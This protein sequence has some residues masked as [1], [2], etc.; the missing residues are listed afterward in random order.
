MYKVRNMDINSLSPYIRV[1]ANSR[2]PAPFVI[3]PRCILDYELIM[4]EEGA[5][6][7]TY[8]DKT[9]EVG[10]GS[11]LFFRPGIVHSIEL[12][13][14]HP[15][16]TQPHIHFDMFFDVYSRD[17]YVCFKGPSQL[18]KSD[19][20]MMRSDL[21]A[22][23]APPSPVLHIADLPRF[24]TYFMDIISA[25]T[26]KPPHHV[27]LLK[28]KMLELLTMIIFDNFPQFLNQNNE[29]SGL[30]IQHIKNYIDDNLLSVIT[31]D[32]LGELFNFNKY[33]ILRKFREEYGV[34]P[35]KYHSDLRLEYA[36]T[37]LLTYSVTDVAHILNY[38]SI[39]TF[40]RAFITKF[41]ISPTK[42]KTS[43]NEINHQDGS[44]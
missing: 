29:T 9:F 13:E 31:L 22:D 28:V 35:M 2:E 27:M 37:L 32:K 17:V 39:Y 18:S 24:R 41:G 19:R 30:N 11:V 3:A 8:E 34:S 5:C 38:T 21:F 14:G 20:E 1:A 40:S 43:P 42:W 15:F 6:T 7:V 25:F 12:K 26:Y 23:V 16:V 36:K 33:Y 44:L 4:I 10:P